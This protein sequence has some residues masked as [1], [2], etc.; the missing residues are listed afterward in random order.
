[1]GDGIVAE[2]FE[3]GQT[4]YLDAEGEIICRL[5]FPVDANNFAIILHTFI[6][7]RDQGYSNG[8]TEG[9]RQIIDVAHELLG[10]GRIV[11]A[12]LAQ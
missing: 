3:T 7:G 4:R 10:I 8:V 12:I 9:R 11:D 2:V 5:P 6:S 1:M